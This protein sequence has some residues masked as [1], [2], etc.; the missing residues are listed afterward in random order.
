MSS[1]NCSKCN[2]TSNT[3][4]LTKKHIEN[5]K[6][7]GAT[8][9][10]NI[11]KV[12]CEICSKEFDTERLLANHKKKCFEKKVVIQSTYADPSVIENIIKKLTDMVAKLG[13]QV[14]SLELENATLN[15][16]I[17]KL[18]L[19]TVEKKANQ[20]DYDIID[21]NDLGAASCMYS[22]KIEFVPISK[23]HII[24]SAKDHKVELYDDSITMT[25]DG[26]RSYLA[27]G[28]F[29]DNDFIEI[30]GVNYYYNKNR[31]WGKGAKFADQLKVVLI[32]PLCKQPAT[33]KIKG[34]EC[35]LCDSH[36][37]QF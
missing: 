4:G 18:E 32:K 14:I 22:E 21:K 23:E 2:Y 6:C 16:R 13:E 11:V 33:R 8:L 20:D 9:I 7:T 15:K 34:T 17:E 30:D 12:P 29:E 35:G 37:S 31:K 24:G 3:K 10:E 25:I 1:Y 19:K 5:T 26:Q 27:H 36:K 28:N